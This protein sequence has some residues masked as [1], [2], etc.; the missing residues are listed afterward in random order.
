MVIDSL[1]IHVSIVNQFAG[2]IEVLECG[3]E[4]F[5]FDK[6]VKEEL[7]S[8][9]IEPGYVDT[10]G[11]SSLVCSSSL[12]NSR[13]SRRGHL[14]V[15]PGVTRW[16]SQQRRISPRK[17]RLPER[18]GILRQSGSVPVRD[19][20]NL[21]P[22]RKIGS[23]PGPALSRT[24]AGRNRAN[25]APHEQAGHRDTGRHVRNITLTVSTRI[26]VVQSCDAALTV[27]KPNVRSSK[28]ASEL[29][30]DWGFSGGSAI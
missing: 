22:P 23:G 7:S 15:R 1:V 28:S 4:S 17:N 3:V 27:S 11:A 19:P 5:F 20:V 12:I 25:H 21:S 9:L 13:T 6:S 29:S 2:L 30:A 18:S 8:Q 10:S 16:R 14:D 26:L 24:L